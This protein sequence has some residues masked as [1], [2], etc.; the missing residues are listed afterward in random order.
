MNDLIENKEIADND[1][2][3]YDG[4]LW[5]VSRERLCKHKIEKITLFAEYD[6]S[7]SLADIRKKHPNV[8]MVIYESFMHGEIYRYGNHKGIGWEKVG[9][10]V[11]FA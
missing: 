6:N 1:V 3:F 11:G 8:T 2:V 10:T 5:I 7:I 9:T 4:M